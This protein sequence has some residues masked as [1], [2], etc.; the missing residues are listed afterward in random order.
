[1]KSEIPDSEY[2]LP[3]GKGTVVKEGTDVT[4]FA[5]GAMVGL[6]KI[7]AQTVEAEG[8]SVEILDPRTLAPLDRELILD[9]I[10]KTGRLVVADVSTETC[11]AASEVAALVA[12]DGFWSLRAPIIRVT[13][14]PTHIPFSP[15]MERPLFPT[16]DKIASA[17]RK[18]MANH[19][20]V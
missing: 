18:V 8:I 7:A 12:Q 20:R 4:V 10:K 2:L 15:V 19:V 13:T 14:P 11:S 6:A 1:M 16:A 3:L 5:V 9:S 17:I